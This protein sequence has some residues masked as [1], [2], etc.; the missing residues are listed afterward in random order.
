VRVI[1]AGILGQ[2]QRSQRS[3]ANLGRATGAKRAEAGAFDKNRGVSSR[4]RI[5]RGNSMKMTAS[6]SC[7]GS[8]SADPRRLDELVA[9]AN[10]RK[11]PQASFQPALGSELG[12][13]FNNKTIKPCDRSAAI[14]ASHR[15]IT[16]NQDS[17]CALHKALIGIFKQ[18]ANEGLSTL[19]G[20]SRR[21]ETHAP[22]HSSPPA[23]PTAR[24][25]HGHPDFFHGCGRPPGD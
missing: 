12:L 7:T 3:F 16:A 25:N 17:P 8:A 11:Q 22:A 23:A 18:F 2:H 9:F 6:P 1:S 14:I 19:G 24:S 20:V 4:A 5:R 10:A 15:Q 21:R 13:A